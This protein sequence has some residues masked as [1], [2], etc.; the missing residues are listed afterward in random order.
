MTT[1]G[2]K[3]VLMT[4]GKVTMWD[5]PHTHILLQQHVQDSR[6]A[7]LGQ[8][9]PAHIASQRTTLVWLRGDISFF[10]FLFLFK[11]E[12]QGPSSP[13]LTLAKLTHL[14]YLPVLSL[15]CLLMHASHQ[16]RPA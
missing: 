16:C 7:W 11:L 14:L 1:K 3:H 9:H 6:L 4:I 10:A 15:P 12:S 8:G 2:G 13:I 5:S